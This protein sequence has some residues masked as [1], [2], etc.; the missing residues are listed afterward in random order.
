MT[1]T[2]GNGSG[3]TSIHILLQ[4]KGEVGKSLIS[5]VLSQYLLSKGQDMRGTN[6]DTLKMLSTCIR[7][8]L[9]V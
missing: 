7:P 4:G 5:A 6:L 1:R 8:L 2:I 9:A 3:G